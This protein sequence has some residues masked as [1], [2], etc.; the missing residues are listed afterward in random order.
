[1]DFTRPLQHAITVIDRWLAYYVATDQ[2]IPGLSVGIVYGDEVIYSKGHGYANLAEKVPATEHTCYRIAS[3]SK[4]FTTIAI[5]QLWEQG[6]LALD[7]RVER[8]LPWFVSSDDQRLHSITLRHLLTHTAG[9]ERDGDT[10]HWIDF[11]FP[12]LTT[13]QQHI[14][15]GATVYATLEQWKYSN[16]G[17]TLLGEVIK[18]VSGISYEEY[19]TR[20]IVERLGLA[21]TAPTL[22]QDIL[23]HLA[24]GYSRSLP[25]QEKEA[26]PAIE[27]NAMASAT[28]FSSNV[29]DLCQFMMA[30][31][32]GNTRLLEDET[33]HEMRRIQ[34][35]RE[36]NDADWCV[37]FETWTVNERRLYGHGGSFPGY[38]SHF[39][40]DPER[41]IGVVVLGN[42]IDVPSADIAN[43]IW[44]TIHYFI[45]HDTEFE[46]LEPAPEN[47][48]AYLGTYRN[49]WNDTEVI[50]IANRLLL[51]VPG[52]AAPTTDMDHLQYEQNGHYRIIKGNSFGH[53]GEPVRFEKLEDKEKVVNRMFVGPN[54]S[55]RWDLSS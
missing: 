31:F 7:D 28:G 33:K 25:N 19:V 55:T 27:T 47:V 3:F 45:T 52:P 35:L 39:G 50:S 38:K 9:L 48:E 11:Q 26:F 34:W 13:I 21:H 5:L 17:F 20:N 32:D 4:I 2:R 22:T 41:A 14:A 43:K 29:Q 44:E 16:Y 12:D 40:I 15:Q 37:G 24:V 8:Y 36:E 18:Q 30:L 6:K 54:P 51:Y 53:V 42:A 49:I 46:L 10:P 1:M 23:A